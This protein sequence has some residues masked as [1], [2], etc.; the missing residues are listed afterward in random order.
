MIS[1]FNIK[2]TLLLLGIYA[3]PASKYNERTMKGNLSSLL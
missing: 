1:I 3:K 2:S